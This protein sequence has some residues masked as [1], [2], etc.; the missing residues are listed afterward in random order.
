MTVEKGKFC[1]VSQESHPPKTY[2]DSDLEKSPDLQNSSAVLQ[3]VK[4]PNVKCQHLRY[5]YNFLDFM[6]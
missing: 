4:L 6:A 5:F 1:R 2:D 3:T